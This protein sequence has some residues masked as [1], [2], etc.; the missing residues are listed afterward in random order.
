MKSSYFSL[1]RVLLVLFGCFVSGNLTAQKIKPDALSPD[2]LE[3]YRHRAVAM[4][5]TGIILTLSGAGIVATSTIIANIPDDGIPDDTG[6]P[7]HDGVSIWAIAFADMAGASL[8]IAG[9]P[10]WVTGGSRK[11][12]AEIALKKFQTAPQS[13]LALGMVIK[14]RF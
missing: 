4:R 14:L 7:S 5:N 13:S 11:A 1:Q 2:Q 8:A 9:I 10:L 12:K 3:L 6:D